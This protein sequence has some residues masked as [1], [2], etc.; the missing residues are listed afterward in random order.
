M[1]KTVK[2]VHVHKQYTSLKRTGLVPMFTCAFFFHLG[3]QWDWSP[4]EKRRSWWCPRLQSLGEKAHSGK[5]HTGVCEYR[6]KDRKAII[7][8]VYAEVQRYMASEVSTVCLHYRKDAVDKNIQRFVVSCCV[9]LPFISC[10]R[11]MVVTV[12]NIEFSRSGTWL[13]GGIWSWD[14]FFRVLCWSRRK[15]ISWISSWRELWQ[16]RARNTGTKMQVS[17][18]WG[19]T[20]NVEA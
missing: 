4:I 18:H 8:A 3:T 6:D 20:Y 5:G 9:R 16:T 11:E 14:L 2:P 19:I 1:I 10:H 17:K 7:D 13:L 15:L 12:N